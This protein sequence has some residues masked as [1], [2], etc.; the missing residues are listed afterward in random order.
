[1]EGG[2]GDVLILGVQSKDEPVVMRVLEAIR[3]V[4]GMRGVLHVNGKG[5][6]KGDEMEPR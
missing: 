2:D 1:M 5:L 4:V 6:E 3:M